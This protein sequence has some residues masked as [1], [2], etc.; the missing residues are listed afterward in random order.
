MERTNYCDLTLK[1]HVLKGNLGDTFYYKR[2][3]VI[4]NSCHCVSRDGGHI[5]GFEG[6]DAWVS[7][8]IPKSQMF[9]ADQ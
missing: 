2:G 7:L 6:G 3:T 8:K 5:N 4:Y 9:F 1:S